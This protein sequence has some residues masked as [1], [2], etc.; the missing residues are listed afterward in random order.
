QALLGPPSLN[1]GN[2]VFYDDANGDGVGAIMKWK[3]GSKHLTTLVS[4]K[5][6]AAPLWVGVTPIPPIPALNSANAAYTSEIG[7]DAYV[8]GLPVP[9]GDVGRKLYELAISGR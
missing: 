9:L 4:T 7:L 8:L 3:L 5:N 6:S 1:R 2:L